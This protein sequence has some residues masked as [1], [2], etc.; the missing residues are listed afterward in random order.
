LQVFYFTLGLLI[1]VLAGG[2]WLSQRG[3]TVEA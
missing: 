2:M 3:E 1:L